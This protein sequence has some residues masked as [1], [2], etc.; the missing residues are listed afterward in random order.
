MQIHPQLALARKDSAAA[1]RLP[2][3]AD[4][5]RP[6]QRCRLRRLP[7]RM[8][9]ANPHARAERPLGKL[10]RIFVIIF[11][12]ISFIRFGSG[13]TR[14]QNSETQSNFPIAPRKRAAQRSSAASI[15]SGV[16][17]TQKDLAPFVAAS[18][19][20][21]IPL[22]LRTAAP[23]QF[24]HEHAAD[25]SRRR[26]GQDGSRLPFQRSF[27]EVIEAI[28]VASWRAIRSNLICHVS[29]DK[30]SPCLEL[31]HSLR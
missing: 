6:S 5:R 8:H 29:R 27:T 11:A 1:I 21:P 17:A 28:K 13:R 9:T 25:K 31:S 15:N 18:R 2:A 10:A 22:R 7:L 19:R 24:P 4:R 12:Q 16:A 3:A 26:P 23:I 14:A 20:N 30:H